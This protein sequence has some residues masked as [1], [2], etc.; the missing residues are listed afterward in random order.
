VSDGHIILAELASQGTKVLLRSPAWERTLANWARFVGCP[1][2]ANLPPKGRFS[3]VEVT[4]FAPPGT[5]RFQGRRLKLVEDSTAVTFVA[6]RKAQAMCRDQFSRPGF[7][8][9]AAPTLFDL[10]NGTGAEVAIRFDAE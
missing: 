3:I 10:H 5:V 1:A 4:A 7:W 8:M 2:P 9:G 6:V